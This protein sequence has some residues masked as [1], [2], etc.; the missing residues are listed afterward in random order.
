MLSLT[1][2]PNAEEEIAHLLG[3]RSWLVIP[4]C[5]TPS[6]IPPSSSHFSSSAQVSG[7]TCQVG[8]FACHLGSPWSYLGMADCT[9]RNR[10]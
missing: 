10:G 5:Q 4:L 7:Q 6:F 2:A 8:L 9:K 1:S 3:W